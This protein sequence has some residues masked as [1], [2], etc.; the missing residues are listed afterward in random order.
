MGSV[1]YCSVNLVKDNCGYDF[2]EVVSSILYCGQ[3]ALLSLSFHSV[4]VYNWIL[5]YAKHV[6][7]LF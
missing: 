6:F 1:T 2:F 5:T 4:N 3:T 7:L